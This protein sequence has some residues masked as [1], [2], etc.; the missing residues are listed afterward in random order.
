[1][2][3]LNGTCN[4]SDICNQRSVCY[5]AKLHEYMTA[6]CREQYCHISDRLCK[7]ENNMR[8]KHATKRKKKK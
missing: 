1:M 6:I 5:H 2:E 7:C 3:L 4:L 8:T